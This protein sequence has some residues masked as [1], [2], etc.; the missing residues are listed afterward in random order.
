MLKVGVAR[1]NSGLQ[2][3][4]TGMHQLLQTNETNVMVYFTSSVIKKIAFTSVQGA[5]LGFKVLNE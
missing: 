3:D 4:Q 1:V 2:E 5:W